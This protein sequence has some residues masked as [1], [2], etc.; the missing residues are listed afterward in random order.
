MEIGHGEGVGL[1]LTVSTAMWWRH[2]ARLSQS[3][4]AFDGAKHTASGLAKCTTNG[5]EVSHT[6]STMA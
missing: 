1:V 4:S 3:V 6:L 5:I 2:A